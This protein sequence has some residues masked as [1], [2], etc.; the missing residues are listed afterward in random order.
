VD[1]IVQPLVFGL[2]PL[3]R[4]QAEALQQAQAFVRTEQDKIDAAKET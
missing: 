4:F 1:A 3:D 2:M